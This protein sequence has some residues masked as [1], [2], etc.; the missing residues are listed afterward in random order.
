MNTFWLVAKHEY[1]RMVLRRAFVL[2]TLLI[3]VGMAAVI[4]LAFLVGAS[5]A[6]KRP[7]GYVDHTQQL[8]ITL[9]QNQ[10]DADVELRPFS[11]EATAQTALENGDIQAFFVLPASYPNPRQTDLYFLEDPPNGDTWGA[12]DDFVRLNYV[13]TLDPALRQQLLDGPAVVVRDLDSGRTFS[14]ASIINI[15]LP[16]VATFIFFIAT[17]SASGYMIQVVAD[18]K[19]NRTM[20]IMLTSLSPFQL[21]GG[22]TVGLL[23]VALTQL[24]IY[25]LTL[26][27]GLLVARPYVLELQTAVIPW[28]YL[29]IMAL[30]FLP[31]FALI[32]GIMVAIG[33]IVP[34]LQQGQQ[35]A[36]LLNFLFILPIFLLAIIIENPSAPLAVAFTLFPTT[37][38]LTVSL[39]WGLGSV[40]LWQLG[41]SWVILVLTAVFAV[42]A[43]ARIFRIGMLQY[44]QP[45][46]WKTAVAALHNS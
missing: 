43:A 12:F 10:P 36:G 17:M 42:W 25:G 22:K 8:D 38:F 3:P 14:S 45:L 1:R 15:I 19:E 31:A 16:F 7:L 46:S 18:E 29:G 4:G 35:V 40:P 27:V 30:F 5:A 9:W 11:N 41:T 26:V 34:N 2:T 6:D 13:D 32:A 33:S 39:R 28:V 20:E 44:G 23:G 21:I 24:G 37:A